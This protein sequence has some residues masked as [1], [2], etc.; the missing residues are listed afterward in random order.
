MF[1]AFLFHQ[2]KDAIKRIR[3]KT[4]SGVVSSTPKT[5]PSPIVPS[6]QV[7]QA[8]KGIL[9]SVCDIVTYFLF[10]IFSVY[11]WLESTG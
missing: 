7:I 4:S 9:S 5:K 2:I 8:G 1:C 10:T 3:D 6:K 11:Y